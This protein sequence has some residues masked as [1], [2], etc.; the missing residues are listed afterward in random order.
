MRGLPG[1]PTGCA[2]RARYPHRVEQSFEL[3]AVVA[4]TAGEHHRQRPALA[5]PG[6]VQLGPKTAPAAPQGLARGV[7][8]PLFSS[9]AL[10]WL[11][12]PAACWW[13]RITV[14]SALT[15]H[16]AS[17]T[18]SF[19]VWAWVSKRSQVPSRLQRLK[20]SKQV[21]QG[22]YLP[23]RSRQGENRSSISRGCR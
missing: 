12:A 22:P 21:C 11:L 7:Q 13:A 8:Q 18:A 5:V 2:F 10:G 17:P 16:S 20:R 3:G 15:S 19:L 4:L 9:A 14:S 23:G 6:E 1:A